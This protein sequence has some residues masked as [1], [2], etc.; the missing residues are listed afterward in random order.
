MQKAR[1]GE[2]TQPRS[3]SEPAAK[4]G[5]TPLLPLSS[6][7]PSVLFFV[8]PR[9]LGHR[10]GLLGTEGLLCAG[11]G[12]GSVA[13]LASHLTFAMTPGAQVSPVL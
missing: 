7:T 4:A 2:A 10:R 3:H 5:L 12:A 6:S 1:A 13:V 11:P 8:I 9:V